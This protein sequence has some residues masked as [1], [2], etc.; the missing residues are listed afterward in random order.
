MGWTP[1]QN[2]AMRY[3]RGWTGAGRSDII[4]HLVITIDPFE[5]LTSLAYGAAVSVAEIMAASSAHITLIVDDQFCDL[6]NVGELES[7]EVT[8]P[9]NQCYPSDALPAAAERL[10]SHRG[11]LSTD[12]LAVVTEYVE[13]LP[14]EV[15]RMLHGGPD[16]RGGPRVRGALSL[17]KGGR[18]GVHRRGSRAGDGPGAPSWVAESR[19]SSPC[20]TRP[21]R[22]SENFFRGC[23]SSNLARSEGGVS[24]NPPWRTPM[25]LPSRAVAVAAAAG[26]AAAPLMMASPAQAAPGTTSLGDVLLADTVEG[27]PSF[28]KNGRDFDILTAAV[29][30]VLGDDADSP[31][32]V[33]LDGETTLTAFIPTD[34]GFERTAA[35][36]NITA[37]NE[38]NLTGK[39]V[40]ALG[41]ANIEQ[42]LLYHVAPGVKINAKTAAESDGAKLD[43]ANGQTVGVNVTKDGIFLKDKNKDLDNPKVVV[44][45]INKGNKQIAHA[46]NRVLLPVL[47]S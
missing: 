11:Y 43:M 17:P 38:A 13:S 22:T 28:D 15:A 46:I 14:G 10:L 20:R 44:T 5:E 33:L 36:L 18:A 27:Q 41:L 47:P 16:R 24:S 26:L 35:D 4:R 32:K 6:V 42:I 19:A 8:F 25:K 9:V 37:K 31:V 1:P 34:A 21:P 12:T 29:L 23:A 3:H 39:L 45:D 40:D 7:H 30:A 2:A